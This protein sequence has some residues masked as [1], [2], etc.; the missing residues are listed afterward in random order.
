MHDVCV[1]TR[2]SP[3]AWPLMITLGLHGPPS[4]ALCNVNSP[5]AGGGRGSLGHLLRVRVRTCV[6]MYI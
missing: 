1:H 4:V 5:A 3:S 2:W 6:C